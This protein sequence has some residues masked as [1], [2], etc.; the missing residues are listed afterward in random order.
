MRRLLSALCL[1]AGLV[2]AGCITID[3]TTTLQKDMSGTQAV[4]LEFD[5]DP[6]VSMMAKMMHSLGGKEGEPTEADLAKAREEL[7]SAMKNKPMNF[8]DEIKNSLG[9]LPAGL[10]L[11]ESTAKQDGL[12]LGARMV[13]AFDNATKLG[14]FKMKA[15]ESLGAMPV[16]GAMESPFLGLNIVEEPGAWV[17]TSPQNQLAGAEALKLDEL[18]ADPDMK[19]MFDSM[20][21]GFKVTMRLTAPFE[22]LEHTATRKDGNTLIWEFDGG[23]IEKAMK[24]G[25]MPQIRVRYKK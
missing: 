11:L 16:P 15:P 4:N 19:A 23:T 2:T 24:G 12:K 22:V 20:F 7:L 13:L 10:K 8:A 18:Q 1:L 5:M 21:K 17:L 25:S 3:Q 14:T 6:F 9:P